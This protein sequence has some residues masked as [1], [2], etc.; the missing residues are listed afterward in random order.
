[1][2]LSWSFNEGLIP[3]NAKKSKTQITIQNIRMFNDGTYECHGTTLD[4]FQFTAVSRIVVKSEFHV[5]F[6]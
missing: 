6:A 1:M 3:I 5:L 2:F 4:A